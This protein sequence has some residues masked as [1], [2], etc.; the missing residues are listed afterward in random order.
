MFFCKTILV[1]GLGLVK[2]DSSLGGV[3]L[4]F[5]FKANGF[6]GHSLGCLKC[7]KFSMTKFVTQITHQKRK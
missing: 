4:N 3:S 5:N 2:R 7:V 6:K 1:L